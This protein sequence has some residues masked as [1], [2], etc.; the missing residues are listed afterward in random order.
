MNAKF[1]RWLALLGAVWFCGGIAQAQAQNYPVK[2][3]RLLVGYAAGGAVDF[4]ARIMAQRLGEYLGQQVV[5][6]NRAGAGSNIASELVAKAPPDGYTLLVANIAFAVNPSLFA[7]LP[8]DP[9]RDFAPVG[10]FTAL[11]NVLVVH[12]SV[13]VTSVKELIALAKAKPGKLNYGSAGNGSSTHLA[14]ELFKNQA[15]LN[16]VH[17]PYNGAAPAIVALLGGQVDLMFATVPT[18]LPQVKAGRMRALAVASAQRSAV[19]PQWP[20]V[21][22]SGLP[23]FEVSSWIGIIAP[24]GTP[25]PII[26]RVNQEIGKIARLPEIQ[27]QFAREGGEATTN[28]PE[29]FAAYI[30]SEIAKW[31]KV[32]QQAKIRAG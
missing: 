1:A 8:F 31:G 12:P 16:I 23:G 17:I 28:T 20:T 29:Q 2:P 22:E 32:V 24:A 4:F 10:Q 11:T 3:V 21:A 13:P 30:K 6:D 15:G 27:E 25:A 5:V 18:A 7:K 14:A 26:A 9:V 19:A